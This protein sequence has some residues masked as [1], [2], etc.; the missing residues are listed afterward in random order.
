MHRITAENRNL[1][2]LSTTLDVSEDFMK[3]AEFIRKETVLGET[4][5]I[6]AT[7]FAYQSN[8]VILHRIDDFMKG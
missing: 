8:P 5:T 6:E 1:V 4:L 2:H 3:I 7:D